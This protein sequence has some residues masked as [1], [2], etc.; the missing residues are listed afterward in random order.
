MGVIREDRVIEAIFMTVGMIT[1]PCLG[2]P[3]ACQVAKP[4]G[5][6]TVTTT[7]LVGTLFWSQTAVTMAA[8]P[9][10][11]KTR[12]IAQCTCTNLPLTKFLLHKPTAAA[13]GETSNQSHLDPPEG[14][15]TLSSYE[16]IT[17][18]VAGLVRYHVE[19]L[20]P[21]RPGPR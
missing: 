5:I 4:A 12:N 21:R 14:T 17:P 7:M 1:Q 10:R 3:W 9:A 2:G 18:I 20:R 16:W 6:P 11:H 19:C 15:K 8:T 13:H